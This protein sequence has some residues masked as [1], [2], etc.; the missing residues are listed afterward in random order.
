VVKYKKKRQRHT[1]DE[2]TKKKQEQTRGKNTKKKQEQPRGKNTKKERK[3]QPRGQTKKKKQEQPRGKNTEIE[4]KTN[5]WQTMPSIQF[6]SSI[7]YLFI[8]CLIFRYCLLNS[9]A[10]SCFP[11]YYVI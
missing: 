7:S 3:R 4:T 2:N 9:C 10:Y 1:R 11:L 5:T 6:Q 8:K